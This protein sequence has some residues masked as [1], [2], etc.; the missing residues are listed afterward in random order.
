MRLRHMLT[1]GAMM[2]LAAGSLAPLP[3]PHG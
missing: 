2:A 3:F 1:L